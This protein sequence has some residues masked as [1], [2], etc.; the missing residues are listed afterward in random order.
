MCIPS[1]HS[2][3]TSV[4]LHDITCNL[5]DAFIQSDLQ[6]IRLTSQVADEVLQHHLALGLDVGAVHVGVEEDDGEGQDEDGVGVVELLHH[7][8]VAHA[9]ALAV[10]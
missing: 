1:I 6:L 9:V 3:E 2:K 10:R 5:A 4:T 7:V 8:R